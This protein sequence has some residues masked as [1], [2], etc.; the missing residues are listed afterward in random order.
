VPEGV[1]AFVV[2]PL[3]EFDVAIAGER[4]R[5]V[6]LLVVKRCCEHRA[7]QASTDALGYFEGR[8]AAFVLPDATV[9]KLHVNHKN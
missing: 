5:Q 3:K 1:L 9:R 2:V 4:A 8:D 6:P 7:S